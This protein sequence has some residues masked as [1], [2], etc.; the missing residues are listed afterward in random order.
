MKKH[1]DILKTAAAAL[2]LLLFAACAN[3]VAPPPERHNTA[4]EIAEGKG[5][6]RIGT[7]AGLARTAVPTAIFD[8]FEYLFS[9]DGKPAAAMMPVD[10]GGDKLFELDPGSWSVTVRAFMGTGEETL[11]AQGTETFT[12]DPG[13]E[14]SVTV[15]LSPVASEGTGTLNYTLTYPV[16]ATVKSFTLTLLADETPISLTNTSGITGMYT[17]TL[18]TAASGYYLARASLEKDGVMAGKIEVAHIYHNMTTELELE[19][20][21]DDFKALVVVSSADSGPGTLREALTEA[22]TAVEGGA[23]ILIDLPAH[24]RVITLTSGSLPEI[25]KGLTIGGN[26]ATLTQNGVSDSLLKLSFPSATT[27]EVH[28]S[29]LYFKGG[30]KTTAGGAINI[31]NAGGAAVTLE[32]CIFSDNRV[33][34]TSSSGGGA[35]YITGSSSIVAISGC[36]FYGNSAGYWGGA[37]Y[38]NG[39]S[40]LTLTGNIFWENTAYQRP[41]VYASS[42]TVSGGFNVSDKASGTDTTT[43]SGWT[44]TNGDKQAASLPVSFVSFRPIMGG[45]ALGVIT[46]KPANYPA[47]DFYG[48]AIPETD[49][50]AGAAQTPTTG[51][52]YILDYVPQGPGTVTVTG[53]TVDDDG[54][55]SGSVT[56]TAAGSE[57]KVLTGWFVDGTLYPEQTIPNQLTL[58]IS[59]HTKVRAVFGAIHAIPGDVDPAGSLHE[60]M[61]AVADGDKILLPAGETITLTSPLPEITKSIFIEGNGATLTQSGFTGSNSPLLYI[62]ST[63]AEVHIS[64]LRFKGGNDGAIKNR[65]KLTL[66]SCIFSD[67]KNEGYGGAINT[68]DRGSSLTVFGCTFFGNSARIDMRS[69]GAIWNNSDNT[70][71]TGNV[72]WGNTAQK[73]NVVHNASSSIAV[74]GGFNVS[75]K[76][77]GTDAALGSG[78]VFTNGDKQASSLPVSALSFRPVGGGEALGG[79]TARPAGYPVTDFYGVPIPE[80]GAAAGAVQMPATGSGYFLDYANQGPG[81]VTITSGTVDADGFISG[82]VTLTASF[83]GEKAVFNFWTV[84]GTAY[85]EQTPPNQL[86]LNINNH[87]KVRAVFGAIHTI[88]N[89]GTEGNGSL[90]EALSSA[91]EWDWIFLPPGATITLASRLTINKSIII[92]GNGATLTQS[93][94]VAAGTATQL[95]YVGP[96]AAGVRISRLHFT[97]GSTTG[98][99]GAIYNNGGKLTLESC[100]FSNNTNKATTA[101]YGGGA[102]Y[103]TYGGSLTVLGCT[104]YGNSAPSASG[105]AIFQGSNETVTLTGNVFWGNTA[106]QHNVVYGGS[107]ITSGGFNISDKASGTDAALGSGWTFEP[108]D[109]QAIS[110][111]VSSL[112]FKPI[113]GGAAVNVITAK[114]ADYP[115]A[116]FYGA[117]IPGTGVAAGAVQTPTTGTGY[118]LDYAGQ[119]PGTVAVTDGIIDNE[120]FASGSVTLT[121]TP[122]VSADGAFMYWTIGGTKQPDQSPLNELV[123]NMDAHKTVRAVFYIKVTSAGDAGPGTLRDALANVDDG[124]GIVLAGQTITLTSSYLSVGRSIVIEG[125]GATLTQSG[126]TPSSSSSLLRISNGVLEVRISR[127]HFKGGRAIGTGAAAIDSS[128]SGLVLVE[129]CIFS[130]NSSVYGTI[131][132]N[133]SKLTVSSCTFCRNSAERGIIFVSSST[134]SVTLTGNIFWGNITPQKLLDSNATFIVTSGGY[135]VSERSSSTS[136]WTFTNG[137]K[138][139][140]SLPVSPLSFKPIAGGEAVNVIT[141]KPADYP[142]ADFYGA[143][144][145]GTGAAAGA[146]QTATTGSGYFLDYA[147]QGPGTV[148]A[149]TSGSPDAD[150]LIS[151][152]VT[153][154]ATPSANGVFMYWT[155]DGVEQAEQ[156][157][158]TELTVNMDAHKTVQAV[159]YIGVTSAGDTGPGTLRDAL[160]N[161][162]AGGGIVLA[163]QTITLSSGGR[164]QIAKNLTIEGNGATLTQ[165]GF[166]PSTSSQLLYNGSY[167]VRISRLH[168][169]GGSTTGYGGAI[170]NSG[171]LTLESCVFSNN[172]NAA[173]TT[174]YGGGVVYTSGASASLTVLGCTFY[175]NSAPSSYGGAIYRNGTGALALTGNIFWGNTAASYPVVCVSSGSATS[176]GHNVSD[177]P[178]GTA[179]T[180]SGW[181]FGANDAQL[182]GVSFGVNF[183]PS[184]TGLPAISPLPAGFP[185]LYF[186]GTS[187][188]TT[189]GAMPAQEP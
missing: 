46:A 9:K 58:N 84:D 88:T 154:R 27:A 60:I 109:T 145:P 47:T 176:G 25:S 112:S 104:F 75:D 92:E 147:G 40:S 132:S 170:Q 115:A 94:F 101:T 28:I 188:G 143:S 15:K 24:D 130:D 135:N 44:F 52:G 19:F 89:T 129:S 37:V 23:T 102:V 20:V 65:G 73:H 125:N 123:V 7:G 113:A 98:Y 156:T 41:V 8:H 42:G 96:A 167:T 50:A 181:T 133:Q 35:V 66:K 85:P 51:S 124:G 64:R 10:D 175:G 146:I 11:A 48:A 21:D 150:G 162:D 12:I 17:G 186:D 117:S 178:D 103:N 169:T 110:L 149:I 38:Q 79:I 63:T 70:T 148:V 91:A 108:T 93:G 43:G 114:P 80:T 71:L 171:T 141:A 33:S 86:T 105:G 30:R 183:K 53:G 14:T 72:F 163:G 78:W 138:Q 31:S 134:S 95:L 18:P 122:L 67:N 179:V 62:N 165:S 180:G 187:R 83:N 126:F 182:T 173:T 77:S 26:G 68:S 5:L 152:S 45:E 59:G 36:A 128:S 87:T 161:V 155:V 157:T 13:E 69:G 99:G 34:S 74:S 81:T 142:A 136:G 82:A 39:N 127:L 120:G 166:T 57:G 3:P 100:I 56:L 189:P 29:R 185:A 55:I 168:F 1:F 116:D 97:G 153:L 4:V 61:G 2:G 160:A 131:Y 16:T 22:M 121:A 54:F 111:P 49:A 140:A 159:F 172:T 6:V 158:P 184:H 174:T 90:R 144:I 139:A 107:A 106:N 137:D 164:L 76:A 32:S 151:G 177:T 118:I 119:G